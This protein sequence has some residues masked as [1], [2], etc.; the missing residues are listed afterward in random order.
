[1]RVS[2]SLHFKLTSA[3][4]SLSFI[5]FKSVTQ[6]LGTKTLPNKPTKPTQPNPRLEPTTSL[7][8][9]A[10]IFPR[11][12]PSQPIHKGVYNKLRRHRFHHV[13]SP[14]LLQKCVAEVRLFGSAQTVVQIRLRTGGDACQPWRFGDLCCLRGPGKNLFSGT[15]NQTRVRFGSDEIWEFTSFWLHLL[16]FLIYNLSLFTP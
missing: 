1:M 7:P 2:H 5:P 12:Y 10:L 14:V 15:G 4:I 16:P 3:C 11:K 13:L 6:P 8:S 9:Q